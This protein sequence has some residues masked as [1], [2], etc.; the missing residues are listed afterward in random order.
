MKAEITT[1]DFDPKAYIPKPSNWFLPTVEYEGWGRAEFLDP[2]GFIE[3]KTRIQYNELGDAT[4]EMEVEKISSDEKLAFGLEQFLRGSKVA[5]REGMTLM[6]IGTTASN[7]CSKFTVETS[8]GIFAASNDVLHSNSIGIGNLVSF[9]VVE[10]EYA[11]KQPT[12]EPNY[13]VLPLS[14]FLSGFEQHHLELDRHPLR[15]FSTPAIPDDLP[16]ELLFKATSYANSKN[17]LIVF[18]HN[19]SLGFIEPITDYD[20]RRD[21][22]Q[23]GQARNTITAVMV[24]ELSSKPIAFNYMLDFLDVLSLAI[25][26][27]IEA[28]WIEFRDAQGGLVR[29][30]HCKHRQTHFSQGYVPICEWFHL[31]IGQLLTQAGASPD[32]GKSYLQVVLKH[33]VRGGLLNL[34]TE[35]RTDHLCR[36]LEILC[37]HYYLS[38]QNLMERLDE[39]NQ[40]MVQKVIQSAV[41]TLRNAV[42]TVGKTEDLEQ[43]RTLSRIV[44][45]ILNAANAD[46]A[47]GLATIDLLKFYD[48][49][50]ADIVDMYYRTNPRPDNKNWAQVL[51]M[52][53]GVAVHT[54][55]FNV[56]EKKHDFKDAIRITNHLHDILVRLAF[57]IL[58]YDGHYQ[59]TVINNYLA[60][61]PVDWVSPSLPASEL[62]YK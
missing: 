57:K 6:G 48:L 60:N 20:E 38:T 13:W 18:K 59:P 24:G 35:D 29:R 11:K 49:P 7:P 43:S 22:L 62:G 45:R 25:G 3:G 5:K 41:Q 33:I 8:D 47:F 9:F 31:G 40:Q 30:I 53:R 61:K 37:E 58:G 26:V 52:Y 15:I 39:P 17:K 44:E 50:D 10:A 4:V 34:S 16:G 27:E 28:P 56:R 12:N 36:A 42:D 2:V 55:Y 23:G 32:I 46:R 19:N 1:T 21:R 14:N 54:G 51:S